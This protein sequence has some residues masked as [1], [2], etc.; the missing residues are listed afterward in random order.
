MPTLTVSSA[1]Q[2]IM[3]SKCVFGIL[4]HGKGEVDHVGGVAK[5]TIQH[6]IAAGGF[7]S[8]AEEM[9]EMLRNKFREQQQPK[10]IIKE[11]ST[12]SQISTSIAQEKCAKSRLK[13]F[14][15]IDGWSKF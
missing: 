15:T 13:V 12:F 3:D 8:D 11:I 1:L 7:Y 4:E 9:V 5:T 14:N 6:E 2:M 10:Y